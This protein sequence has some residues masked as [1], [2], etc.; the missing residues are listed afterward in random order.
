MAHS[1]T[2]KTVGS[3]AR[4]NILIVSISTR[5]HKADGRT[6]CF[7]I[8][9]I[10]TGAGVNFSQDSE[11]ELNT[12]RKNLSW[13]L[14]H[15]NCPVI[16]TFSASQNWREHNFVQT[17][18]CFFLYIM[19]N[20]PY[21]CVNIRKDYQLPGSVAHLENYYFSAAGGRSLQC[22]KWDDLITSFPGP[23]TI[24]RYLTVL[25]VQ[26]PSEEL[27]IVFTAGRTLWWSDRKMIVSVVQ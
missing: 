19:D 7:I 20:F 13:K 24:S 11:H 10:L 2:N 18:T 25:I 4:H 22:H 23:E 21:F 27:N 26:I 9:N 17:L 1:H 3:W 6:F 15:S 5:Y 12:I 8:W 14:T 16:N